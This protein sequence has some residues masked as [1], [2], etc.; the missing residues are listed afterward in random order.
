MSVGAAWWHGSGQMEKMRP[1]S[2]EP[3]PLT[4]GQFSFLSAP[5]YSQEENKWSTQVF[6]WLCSPDLAQAPGVS[7]QGFLHCRPPL[8]G[9]SQHVSLTPSV[10][11][12]NKSVPPSCPR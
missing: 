9:Q 8:V 12:W 11:K 6:K 3:L 4:G 5:S 2:S 10:H 1:S 7:E